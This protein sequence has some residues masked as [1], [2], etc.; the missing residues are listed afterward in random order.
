M[1]GSFGETSAFGGGFA[2]TSTSSGR[3]SVNGGGRGSISSSGEV[4]RP[5]A[6]GIVSATLRQLSHHKELI[7]GGQ[8]PISGSNRSGVRLV[9]WVERGSVEEVGGE[10]L[11]R[12]TDGTFD[13]VNV[14]VTVG[15]SP[16]AKQKRGE[17]VSQLIRKCTLMNGYLAG[18]MMITGTVGFHND[19]LVVRASHLRGCDPVQATFY[20]PLEVLS[21]ALPVTPKAVP[22]AN[23][24]SMGEVHEAEPKGN[25]SNV[26]RTELDNIQLPGGAE[27]LVDLDNPD[28]LLLAKTITYLAGDKIQ[29]ELFAS[30]ATVLEI[31]TSLPDSKPREHYL[32][33]ISDKVSS[34]DWYVRDDIESEVQETDLVYF[35]LN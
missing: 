6:D 26:T 27:S 15:G 10:F 34:I 31:V 25:D 28:E 16:D 11:F 33:I 17:V 1:F 5:I 23:G 14:L 18:R 29:E 9:G 2:P 22:Q 19:N 24:S 35:L 30:V 13:Y 12:F 32:K 4:V 7:T 21:G 20:H 3:S 8:I